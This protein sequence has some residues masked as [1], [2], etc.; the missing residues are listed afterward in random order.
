MRKANC[1]DEQSDEEKQEIIKEIDPKKGDELWSSFLKDVNTVQNKPQV[2]K[3]ADCSVEQV[4]CLIKK[5]RLNIAM[6]Y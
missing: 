5:S 2:N 3:Y 1:L 6:T 4:G